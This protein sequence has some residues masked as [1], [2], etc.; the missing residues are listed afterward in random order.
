MTCY[1]KNILSIKCVMQETCRGN[2]QRNGVKKVS[3]QQNQGQ[4]QDVN[5]LIKVRHEKLADLQANGKNPFEVMKY[6]VTA[7]SKDIKT[8]YTKCIFQIS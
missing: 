1:V 6:D 3:G 7:H 2:N 5:Q 4:Q 8:K